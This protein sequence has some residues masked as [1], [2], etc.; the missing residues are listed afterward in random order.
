MRWVTAVM[1]NN[2]RQLLDKVKYYWLTESSIAARRPEARLYVAAPGGGAGLFP[3]VRHP[4]ARQWR[5][6][7]ARQSAMSATS[8]VA[9]HEPAS[10]T[11]TSARRPVAAPGTSAANVRTR[12]RSDSWVAMIALSMELR[13]RDTVATVSCG[14]L[15]RSYEIE[16]K[17]PK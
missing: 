17:L 6:R 9:S 12:V 14:L 15:G 3:P 11:I 7:S 2:D 13:P 1:P 16:H 5:R 4:D 8:A 10:A